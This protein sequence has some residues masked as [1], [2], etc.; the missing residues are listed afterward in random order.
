MATRPLLP[1]GLHV[2]E[3]GWLSS[4]NILM[5]GPDSTTLVDSGYSTHASQTLAL[6]ERHLG[7]KKLDL[8]VNTHLHSDHCGANAALQQ[9]YGNLHTIIPPGLAAHVQKW[10]PYKLTYSPTGQACPPFR[11]DSVLAAGT[12]VN[13][14]GRLWQIHAAAGHDPHSVILF[15]PDIRLLIS[16]D[17]LWENGFGVVFPELEGQDAF[18]E[19]AATLD[20]IESLEPRTVIPGHGKVFTDTAAALKTARRRLTDFVDHPIKHAHYAAKVL[21]KFKLLELQCIEQATLGRLVIE[22]PYLKLLQSKY[23]PDLE[24][25]VWAEQLADSLIKSGAAVRDQNMLINC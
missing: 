5:I 24:A 12:E 22:I 20:L 1:D 18:A 13:L 25:A 10:D 6:I 17:A 2:L 14:G 8:L 7:T 19:V 23:F 11:Y 21:L 15:Q 4:N 9:K 3:R 16:A